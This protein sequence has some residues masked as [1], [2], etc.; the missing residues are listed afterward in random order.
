MPK[1]QHVVSTFAGHVWR[2]VEN[3]HVIGGVV[4]AGTESHIDVLPDGAHHLAN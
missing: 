3:G 1:R 2:V 4:A